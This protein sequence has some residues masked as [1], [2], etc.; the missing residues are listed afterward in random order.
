MY[1]TVNFQ[2][3]DKAVLYETIFGEIIVYGQEEESSKEVLDEQTSKSLGEEFAGTS[4]VMNV[5]FTVI[6]MTIILS[7]WHYRPAPIANL[8]EV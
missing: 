4:I 7:H 8:D 3:I 1:D 6:V 5:L 2:I